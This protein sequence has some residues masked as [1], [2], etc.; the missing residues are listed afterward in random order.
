[1]RARFLCQ[2]GAV[3]NEELP[4]PPLLYALIGGRVATA[5]MVMEEFCAGSVAPPVDCISVHSQ[6]LQARKFGIELAVPLPS[7]LVDLLQDILAFQGVASDTALD[8]CLHLGATDI[9]DEFSRAGVDSWIEALQ[10]SVG[11]IDGE[12]D[13]MRAETAA[14]LILSERYGYLY[15]VIVEYTRVDRFPALLLEQHSCVRSLMA[16]PAFSDTHRARVAGQIYDEES[17]EELAGPL[18]Q[19]AS[20]LGDRFNIGTTNFV[21][22]LYWAALVT[23]DVPLASYLRDLGGLRSDARSPFDLDP[24][25]LVAAERGHANVV[26]YCY[27]LHHDSD[28]TFIAACMCG[29]SDVITQLLKSKAVHVDAAVESQGGVMSAIAVA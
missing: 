21:P 10:D 8:L 13:D 16:H 25:V 15:P 6:L 5:R 24:T 11:F 26:R 2:H 20:A 1:M 17:V 4:L 18:L 22:S 27:D 23:G 9:I 7:D 29:R 14:D 3:S 19:V 28:E 12:Y